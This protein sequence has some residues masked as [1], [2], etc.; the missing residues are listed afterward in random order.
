MCFFKGSLVLLERGY[1]PIEKIVPGYRVLVYSLLDK[2]MNYQ[3]YD[4]PK[5]ED[6]V[7]FGYMYT[8]ADLCTLYYKENSISEGVP[9][10]DFYPTAITRVL[11]YDKKYVILNLQFKE[12]LMNPV[13]II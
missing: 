5:Y 12:L 9:N 13:Y 6:V 8:P 1:V 11:N 3:L 10:K 4:E 7:F 2:H